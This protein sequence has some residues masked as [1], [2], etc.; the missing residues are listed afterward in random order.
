MKLS[1]LWLL[2]DFW[3]TKH[4]QSTAE[5][6]FQRLQIISSVLHVRHH[7]C[8][9]CTYFAFM[10][11]DFASSENKSSLPPLSWLVWEIYV[12]FPRLYFSEYQGSSRDVTLQDMLWA[13][14]MHSQNS[15]NF[16]IVDNRNYSWRAWILILKSRV[17]LEK[18][19]LTGV[20]STK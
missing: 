13:D 10:F 20:E 1:Y 16:S 9:F 3:S 11:K 17:E 4:L 2:F 8:I 7:L 14:E 18:D 15:S 5:D 19:E 6:S 12:A